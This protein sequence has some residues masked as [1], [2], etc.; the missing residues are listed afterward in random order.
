[1]Q[2]L[3]AVA[4]LGPV[5]VVWCRSIPEQGGAV[6]L[7]VSDWRWILL[8]EG[9]PDLDDTIAHEVAHLAAW[10]DARGRTIR[11]HGPEWARW[12]RRLLGAITERT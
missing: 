10:R 2:A 9:A 4:G 12:R 6:G 1:M 11:D 5:P 8:Q 3:A 7:A